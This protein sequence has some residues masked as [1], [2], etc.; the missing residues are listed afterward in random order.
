MRLWVFTIAICATAVAAPLSAQPLA[1]G[2]APG[3]FIGPTS[4]ETPFTNPVAPGW[5]TSSVLSVGD[6]TE[7]NGYRMVGIP[8]GLG[9][10]A[11]KEEGG[12]YVADKAYMTIFM[13]HELGATA[14]VVRAHGE[15]GAFVSQMTVHLNSLKVKWGQDLIENVLVWDTALGTF[16]PGPGA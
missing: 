6:A 9:A 7:E 11:G 15:I 5:Q 12:K 8:D 13:N 10:L 2:T 14:G 4:S 3:T 1:P 16:T